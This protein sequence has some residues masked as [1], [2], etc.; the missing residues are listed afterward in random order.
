MKFAI[1]LAAVALTISSAA[2][3]ADNPCPQLRGA[4]TYDSASVLVGD[5]LFGGA[6]GNSANGSAFYHR[7]LAAPAT[8]R[9]LYIL[10][11][12]SDVTSD[13]SRILIRAVDTAGQS[14][15][16]FDLREVAI[17][18][19]GINGGVASG[20]NTQSQ[21]ISFPDMT[22]RRI[23]IDMAGNGWFSWQGTFHTKGCTFP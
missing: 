5:P 23:L 16:L 20:K 11:A 6:W 17:N 14:N 7:N 9:G 3:A 21:T 1:A 19:G 10:F 4:D 22:V 13:G 12:G 8:I 15:V 18:R 2:Y